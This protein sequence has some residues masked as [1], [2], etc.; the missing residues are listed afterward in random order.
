MEIINDNVSV[1]TKNTSRTNKSRSSSWQNKCSECRGRELVHDTRHGSLVCIDCGSVQEDHFIDETD[2]GTNYEAESGA[3]K[4]LSRHGYT[5]K[6]NPYDSLG[7][8]I[9]RGTFYTITKED[10]TTYRTDLSKLNLIVSQNSKEK[11]YNTT[12]KIFET[13]GFDRSVHKSVIDNAKRVWAEITKS[14]EKIFR[15]SNR[16][17]I[18]ASCILYSSYNTENPLDRDSLCRIMEKSYESFTKKDLYHG[19]PIFRNL[20]KKTKYK[21]LLDYSFHSRSKKTFNRLISALGFE[22]GLNKQCLHIYNIANVTSL[23]EKS[24][25][26]GIV[27]EVVKDRKLD[28]KTITKRKVAEITGVTIPT[29]N[30]AF[31]RIS[32]AMDEIKQNNS[33][34]ETNPYMKGSI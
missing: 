30:K 17:G 11:S 34:T 8:Y 28:G 22:Y 26:A 15:G 14:N 12:V 24:I 31:L 27:W 19:E 9:P 33:S 10:G 2:E 13:L 4:D 29:L 18:L 32:E 5:D 25:I 20:V 3:R 16:K 1:I 7:T 21:D 6:F 23:K